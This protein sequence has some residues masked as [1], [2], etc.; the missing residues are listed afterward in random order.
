MR[1]LL[2]LAIFAGSA[3][4]TNTALSQQTKRV[5]VPFSFK[6]KGQTF[7]AGYYSVGT[8]MNDALIDLTSNLDP[9]KHIEVI[10]MPADPRH[11]GVVLSFSV[12][13]ATYVLAAIQYARLVGKF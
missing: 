2:A 4:C 11:D 1:S 12:E 5:D 9:A 13:G 3:L 10:T 8:V 7:P 6:V